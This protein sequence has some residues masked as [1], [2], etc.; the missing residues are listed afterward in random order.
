M[1]RAAAALTV[2]LVVLL[3]PTRSG[4]QAP[5]TLG[6]FTEL[7]RGPDGGQV[8]RGVIP[9]ATRKSMIYVPPGFLP[10]RRYPVIYLLHGMP[11]S[12]WSYVNSLS[13]ATLSDTLITKQLA[14]PFV[15]VV[16]VAGPSGHYSGEWTGPWAQYLVHR[17]VP[18][19]EAHLPIDSAAEARVRRNRHRPAPPK[20]VR[21][22]RVLGRLLHRSSRRPARRGGK[23]RARCE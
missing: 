1:W 9:G 19:V 18:W 21:P 12:P 7:R 16:P 11:G 6:S 8:W 4:A 20:A 10:E 17:V 23:G 14:A 5:F 3:L 15:A 13:L 22:A 2:C